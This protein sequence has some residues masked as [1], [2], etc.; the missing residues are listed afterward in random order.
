LNREGG[1]RRA[2]RS[3]G[4]TIDDRDDSITTNFKGGEAP[5]NDE[6][7]LLKGALEIRV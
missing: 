1:S 3:E 7:S 4:T 6:R 2:E 5:F